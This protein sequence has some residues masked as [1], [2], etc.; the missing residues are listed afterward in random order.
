MNLVSLYLK[1]SRTTYMYIGDDDITHCL[2]CNGIMKY[3][4][5]KT[6]QCD[7]CGR[8]GIIAG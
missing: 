4:A 3:Y 8:R 7:K 2:T 6:I 5:D 1:R